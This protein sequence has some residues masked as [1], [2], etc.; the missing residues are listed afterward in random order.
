MGAFRVSAIGAAALSFVVLAC[1]T[2][3]RDEPEQSAAGEGGAGG[4]S[5]GFGAAGRGGA[6]GGGLTAGKGALAA[7][8][9]GN[10][11]DGGA[12]AGRI[13]VEGGRGGTAAGSG[14]SAGSGGMSA[15]SAGTSAGNGGRGG[16]TSS[17]VEAMLDALDET[18]GAFCNAARTC[19]PAHGEPAM[20]DDC[21][22]LYGTYSTNPLS[23]TNGAMVI[24]AAALARCQ[25]AYADGPEQCNLRAVVAACEGVFVGTRAVDEPCIQG[26]EC[27]RSAGGRVC[28]ITD[29]SPEI[30]V[31]VCR[32]LPHAQ[33]GEYCLSSCRTGED[34]SGTLYGGDEALPFC[35][36]DEGLYCDRSMEEPVCRPLAEVGQPCADYDQCGSTARCDVTCEQASDR[37]EPC[38]NGCISKYQ[39]SVDGE[40]VDPSWPGPSTCAGHALAP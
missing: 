3:K 19:C 1:G 18:V 35:F 17:T 23:I 28:V 39:C 36:E 11:G 38:G 27:D 2:S 5:A 9:G 4:G 8:R 29:T 24:D 12:S 13:A 21:E 32:P 37:G 6:A 15:G 25:A 33:E 7:G 31:G 34:C 22:S 20:L 10:A 40:C 16:S 30:P 26:Y 14:G